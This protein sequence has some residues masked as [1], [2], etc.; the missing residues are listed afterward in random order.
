MPEPHPKREFL[1]AAGALHPHPERVRADIFWRNRFF[2]PLDKVQV[3]Y[4]MLRAHVMNGVAVVE[5]AGAFGFSRQSFYTALA[6]LEQLGILGLADDK[7]GRRG[8][9]KLSGEDIDWIRVLARSEPD[10]SGMMIR[11][12]LSAERDVEVHKRTVERLLSTKKNS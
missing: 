3:K 11:D 7:R 6:A 1:R 5:A 9:M 2:D 12:R 10:L 4:E 8:P